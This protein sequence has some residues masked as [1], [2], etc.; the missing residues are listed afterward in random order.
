M[1]QIGT[2]CAQSPTATRAVFDETAKRTLLMEL[3]TA[4]VGSPQDTRSTSVGE[5]KSTLE[6]L[7]E[8]TKALE[9]ELEMTLSDWCE[10]FPH[11]DRKTGSS[12]SALVRR[13]KLK[14]SEVLAIRGDRRVGWVVQFF[15]GGSSICNTF[16]HMDLDVVKAMSDLM[17]RVSGYRMVDDA[18]TP[19]PPVGAASVSVDPLRRL[20]DN[21]PRLLGSHNPNAWLMKNS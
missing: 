4:L 8:Q 6:S 11:Y 5:A 12:G 21:Q 20:P 17:A 7:R 2:Q 3:A 1:K 15:P 14:G 9:R 19:A 10:V 16:H 18:S 13:D